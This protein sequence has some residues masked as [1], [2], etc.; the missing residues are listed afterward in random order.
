MD[1]EKDMACPT[2]GDVEMT[3]SARNAN[4]RRETTH[5]CGGCGYSESR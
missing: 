3:S 2:C 1:K 4:H 5:T